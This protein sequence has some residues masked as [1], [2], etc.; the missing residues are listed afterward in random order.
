MRGGI[1]D[2]VDSIPID[3]QDSTCK[4]RGESLSAG[5]FTY[6]VQGGTLVTPG[7]KGGKG[8]LIVFGSTV[9]IGCQ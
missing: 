9:E 3:A 4:R 5:Q 2:V 1:P 6:V 8:S 7:G